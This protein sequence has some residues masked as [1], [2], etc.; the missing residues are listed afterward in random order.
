MILICGTPGTGKTLLAK[1][2]AEYGFEI[3]HLSE[4]VIREKLY[5][6]YD[7]AR[8]SFVINPK[9]LI[10]KLVELEKKTKKPLIVEGIGAELVPKKYVDLCIVLICEPKELQKRLEAKGYSTDKIEENLEAERINLIWGEALDK[11][12]EENVVVLDTTN[13]SAEAL[14]NI[15]LKEFK[16]RGLFKESDD[17]CDLKK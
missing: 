9:K 7:E 3:V 1:K 16:K 15:V 11:Y 2:L 14:A 6:N 12:G 17:E 8:Q 4:L 13:L 5:L 10:K